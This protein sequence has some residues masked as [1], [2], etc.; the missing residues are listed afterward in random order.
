[1][2]RNVIQREWNYDNNNNKNQKEVNLQLIVYSTVIPWWRCLFHLDR[3]RKSRR[4]RWTLLTTP[5]NWILSF[6]SI[7]ILLSHPHTDH[8][9]LLYLPHKERERTF[10]YNNW[11]RLK[12]CIR[13]WLLLLLFVIIDYCIRICTVSCM[14]VITVISSKSNRIWW[15]CVESRIEER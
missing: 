8:Q 7:R 10:I 2:E 15:W 5:S 9:H 4:D 1:M 11:W 6:I 14:W 12:W 13:E 3:I